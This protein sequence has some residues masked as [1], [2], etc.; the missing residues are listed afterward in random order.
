MTFDEFKGRREKPE[1]IERAEQNFK[2]MDTNKD[3]KLTLEEFKA[4]QK[5]RAER[6]GAKKRAGKKGQTKRQK[7][8]QTQ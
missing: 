3:L 4:A 2:R 5:K 1:E 6:E 7:A 8:A